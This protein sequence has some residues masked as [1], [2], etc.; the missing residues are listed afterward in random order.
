MNRAKRKT[1]IRKDAKRKRS[2]S[3]WAVDRAGPTT[4]SVYD[5]IS[6]KNCSSLVIDRHVALAELKRWESKIGNG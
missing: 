1:I 4:M 2:N 3:P 6:F 5:E